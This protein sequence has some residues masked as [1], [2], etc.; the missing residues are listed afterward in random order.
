MSGASPSSTSSLMYCFQS[1]PPRISVK[2]LAERFQVLHF[3]IG[4]KMKHLFPLL[5]GG[6]IRSMIKKFPA[7]YLQF[8]GIYD[9][10]FY[11]FTY[12]PSF[13]LSFIFL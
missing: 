4:E 1:V 11:L 7:I 10:I 8:D 6:D 5:M 12:L 3:F 9:G 13:A 2:H